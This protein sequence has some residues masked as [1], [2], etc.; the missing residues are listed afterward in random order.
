MELM[1]EHLIRYLWRISEAIMYFN[2]FTGKLSEIDGSG[3]LKITP[4]W[5]PYWNLKGKY[6][7][8]KTSNDVGFAK[9]E[10]CYMSGVNTYEELNW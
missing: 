7:G 5:F 2:M 1:E 9:P 3:M 8:C 10:G 4:N 6:V